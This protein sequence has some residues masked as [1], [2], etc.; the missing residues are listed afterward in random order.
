MNDTCNK[1]GYPVSDLGA[2]IQPVCQGHGYH[3]EFN[4]GYNPANPQEADRI[5]EMYLKAGEVL[6]NNGGFFSRP[7]DLLANSVFNRDAVSWDAL[8]KLK[9]IYDPNYILNPGKL[10]F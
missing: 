9:D 10:C 1:Y 3:C 7:Y 5:K 4:L 2:Y 6:M 8:K